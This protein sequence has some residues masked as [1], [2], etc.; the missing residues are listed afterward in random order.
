MPRII[1]GSLL[2]FNQGWPGTHLL[3]DSVMG[4][5]STGTFAA[6]KSLLWHSH[7]IPENGG[8]AS[9]RCPLSIPSRAVLQDV[10]EEKSA[11]VFETTGGGG[12]TFEFRAHT[13]AA[14]EIAYYSTFQTFIADAADAKQQVHTIRFCDM[15]PRRRGRIV[16]DAP[17]LVARDV[18]EVGFMITKAGGQRGDYSLNINWVGAI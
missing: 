3:N 9:I 4:G 5:S 10:V 1:L 14:G 11:F 15:I 16:V 6:G 13:I 12:A 8:F 2:G 17:P 7:L 18:D